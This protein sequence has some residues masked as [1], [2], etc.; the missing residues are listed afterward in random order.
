MV[1]DPA[2]EGSVLLREIASDEFGLLKS[3]QRGI[4]W[5]SFSRIFVYSSL[6]ED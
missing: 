2:I 6:N 5:R 1:F 4:D 3:I